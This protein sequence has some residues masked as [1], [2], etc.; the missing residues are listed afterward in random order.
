MKKALL[1]IDMQNV[2]VGENHAAYFKY[3][4][5]ALIETVNKAID[6]NKGNVV[7]YIKNIMKKNFIN[8]FAPFHA[9]EGTE[10]VE[11]VDNLQTVSENVF[12]KYEGNAFSNP[13]LNEFLKKS[14]IECVEVV[15]V[16]G[17]GCVALTALGAIKK[18]YKVIVNENAIGTMFIKNR[19]KYFKQLKDVGAEFV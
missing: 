15:G 9:Y 10:E 2:C 14:D 11:L 12:T 1:V 18:G 16:D 6:A 5:A 4:N 7:I 3:D 13:A 19:D 8:K 17:G